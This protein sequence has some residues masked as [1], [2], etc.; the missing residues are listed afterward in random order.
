MLWA[1]YDKSGEKG[2]K[3]LR[4][5]SELQATGGE[6]ETRGA[7]QLVRVVFAIVAERQN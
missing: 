2:D 6:R 5:V 4:W 3:S 1:R 7:I